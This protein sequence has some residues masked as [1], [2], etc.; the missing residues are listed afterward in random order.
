M[1][2]QSDWESVKATIEA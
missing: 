2:P 1:A